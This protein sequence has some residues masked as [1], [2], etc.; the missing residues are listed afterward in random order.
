MGWAL[1][2]PISSAAIGLML[3][4]EGVVACAA[5]IG[6]AGQ[7]VGFA[8]ASFRENRFGGL[9]ALGIG[10]SML[11][12]PN[13]LKNP[14]IL[15]PPT[16]AGAVSAP[17]GTIWFGL[18][19]NAAGSGMGTSGLVGPLMTF[20]EMGYSGSLFIQV[21]LCYVIIPAVCAFIV[22]EW[23]RRKGWIKWNDMHISFN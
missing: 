6:C 7:M 12:M 15:I 8:V 10:T 16:I 18:L 11:Q 21:I 4:L 14:L 13:I 1:T 22:S 17:I 20:T 5:A 3:G 19:N 23:M 9:L 2:A